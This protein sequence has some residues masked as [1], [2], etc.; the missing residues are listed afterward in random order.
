MWPYLARSCWR[1]STVVLFTFL[2]FKWLMK[3][4]CAT[5]VLL[6][7]SEIFIHGNNCHYNSYRFS[8][9]FA[10]IP[11]LSFPRNQRQESSWWSGKEKHF[12]FLLIGNRTLLQ[13]NDE[14]NPTDFYKGSFLHVRIIFPC[15]FWKFLKNILSENSV[16]S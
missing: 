9:K 8:Y 16:E 14:L 10:F 12:C 11:F 6:T 13:S 7:I 5:R 4:H 2:W 3:K 1:C 15:S